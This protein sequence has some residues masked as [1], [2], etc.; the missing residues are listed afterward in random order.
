MTNKKAKLSAQIG[1]TGRVETCKWLVIVFIAITA[2]APLL[3]V[4]LREPSGRLLTFK[5]LAKAG[6]L[7]A[8]VLFAWQFL[9]GFRGAVSKVADDLIWVVNLHKRLGQAA[10][11]LILLHPVFIS[12]YYRIKFDQ[13]LFLFSASSAFDWFVLAGIAAL[14]IVAVIYL[15]SVPLRRRLSSVSWFTLHLSSYIL[16]PLVL[17]H[18]FAIGMTVGGRERRHNNRPSAQVP[19]GRPCALRVSNLRTA[20]ND[21]RDRSRSQR[22]ESAARPDSS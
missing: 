13:N 2:A 15:T 9:L 16:M 5:L 19:G 3:F 21:H 7:P 17:V 14:A 4:D 11:L 8:T 18:S 12:L 20:D 10:C 1:N 6:S 22:G